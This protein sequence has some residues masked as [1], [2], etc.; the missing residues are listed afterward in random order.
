MSH[1]C[2][3]TLKGTSPPTGLSAEQEPSHTGPKGSFQP[4]CPSH[5][6]SSP[7]FSLLRSPQTHDGAPGRLS[8]TLHHMQRRL[9]L[10]TQAPQVKLMPWSSGLQAPLRTASSIAFPTVASCSHVLSPL[11]ESSSSPGSAPSLR[12]TPAFPGDTVHCGKHLPGLALRSLVV[13]STWT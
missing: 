2:F 1:L 5:L 3:A 9:A 4:C 7:R 13:I 6:A 11:A 12:G 8:L 10:C